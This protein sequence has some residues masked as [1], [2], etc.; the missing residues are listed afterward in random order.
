MRDAFTNLME[1]VIHDYGFEEREAYILLT[2]CPDTRINVYQMVD[3]PTFS[4]TAGLEIPKKYL[5]ETSSW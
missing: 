5:P 3:L 1:W 4:Y 2:V